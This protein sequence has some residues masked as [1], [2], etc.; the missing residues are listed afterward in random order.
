M[1][2]SLFSRF[3]C[4][5][6]HILVLL[7]ALA[8]IALILG[9]GFGLTSGSD[10]EPISN[11]ADVVYESPTINYK[12]VEHTPKSTLLPKDPAPNNLGIYHKAAVASDGKPCAKIGA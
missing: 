9:L 11:G 10:I 2:S 5:K 3:E 7:I 12:L 6:G 1:N 8:I 4:Q